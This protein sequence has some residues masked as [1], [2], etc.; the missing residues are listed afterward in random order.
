MATSPTNHYGLTR[1]GF[2]TGAAAAGLTMIPGLERMMVGVSQAAQDTRRQAIEAAIPPAAPA[3]PKRPRKLLIFDL[4]V[5]Y[6]GHGSIPTANTA[7]TLMGEKTGAFS[8]V[9]SKDPA[10]FRPESLRQFDAVF[11]NNNV[12]NLFTDPALR[13]SLIDFVY[14]GGGMMG[15]H[16]TAVAFTRWDEGAAEDWPEFAIMLGAR[17][18]NHRAADERIMIRL[19]DPD[20][21]VNRPFGG[22]DF[23]YRD[24]FFRFHEAYSR[25]R[26][27]VLM[28]IDIE[29][30]DMKQGK[31]LGNCYRQDGDY[32]LAWVRQYGRGRV[33]YCTIAHNPSVFMDPKMLE[34]YLGAA[35]FVL[36]D[37]PAPTTPSAKRTE[38]IR[39][40]EKLGWR[41]TLSAPPPEEAT[42]YERIDRAAENGLLYVQADYGMKVGGEL[43]VPFDTRLNEDQRRQIRLK[44]DAAGVRLLTCRFDSLRGDETERRG[45][46]EFVRRMGMETIIAK[47]ETDNSGII[48][49]LSKEY[50]IP[51]VSDG[52][53][54]ALGPSPIYLIEADRGEIAAVVEG[55]NKRS[56]QL[57]QKGKP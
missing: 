22:K 12:G 30:S 8:T 31:E 9:I 7:F 48:A 19:D 24:E 32:A 36:G 17:G 37:L 11:F 39:A 23:E 20:H 56:I 42:L 57:A 47:P 18:A 21:P 40:Q 41:V 35:Q 4:N 55:Y 6:G 49:K 43:P 10:V 46:F 52:K 13:Q 34:F 29:K 1:R 38:A 53:A 26:C 5:A 54:A 33:F 3:A 50:N 51:I 27:R 45:T 16:G 44:L 14:G 25:N 2:V 28:S 15:V